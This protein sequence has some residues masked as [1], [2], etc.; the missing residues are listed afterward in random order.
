MQTRETFLLSLMLVASMAACKKLPMLE[1][2]SP[3]TDTIS[4]V[5]P[6]ASPVDTTGTSNDTI[7]GTP[8]TPSDTNVYNI[9][10]FYYRGRNK[11]PPMDSIRRYANDP[12]YDSVY[13]VWMVPNSARWTPCGFYAARDSIRER[14]NLS[15]KVCGGGELRTYQ[16]VPDCDSLSF[17]VLGISNNVA[18]D[19]AGWGYNVRVM[20]NGG[21]K[22]DASAYNPRQYP[23]GL[24][25]SNCH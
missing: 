24:P 3:Q 21:Q 20:N 13:I 4:P 15:R 12:N 5:V 14:M 18:N 2:P 22:P 23:V 19:F 1:Q 8:Q 6:P 17:G 7:P 10:K 9:V 11:V 25:R 16:I